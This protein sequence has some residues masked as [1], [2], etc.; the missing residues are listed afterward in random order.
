MKSRRYVALTH[1][2]LENR[3]FYFIR[4]REILFEIQEK[5]I[6]VFQNAPKR[7]FPSF[8]VLIFNAFFVRFFFFFCSKSPTSVALTS[9]R[10]EKE[11]SHRK[12]YFRFFYRARH[13]FSVI[14]REIDGL[15]WWWARQPSQTNSAIELWLMTTAAARVVFI[16]L[17]FGFFFDLNLWYNCVNKRCTRARTLSSI[18]L[19]VWGRARFVSVTN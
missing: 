13:N 10:V 11:N 17:I 15:S 5:K 4:S 14:V 1:G 7:F 3:R 18:R 19:H 6:N 8:R 12:Y 9:A 16:F 2:R